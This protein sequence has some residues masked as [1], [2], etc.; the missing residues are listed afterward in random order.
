MKRNIYT[1]RI[2]GE[3]VLY[4]ITIPNHPGTNHNITS[5][6][7]DKHNNATAID[8]RPIAT[9]GNVTDITFLKEED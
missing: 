8:K 2:G 1:Y 4:T 7:V 6:I 3:G 9:M 5:H